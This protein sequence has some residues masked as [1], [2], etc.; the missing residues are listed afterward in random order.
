MDPLT[1]ALS[2]IVIQQVGFRRKAALL[3]LV[4]SAVAPDIDYIARI[5]GPDVFLHYHRGITHGFL[6]LAVF[7]AVMGFIFRNKGGFF[8]Y[9]FLSFL[10]YG[11]HLL[12]DLTNQYGTQILAPL[13]WNRYAL[14][15]TFII[16]PYI[17]LGL[18]LA[19]V[20]GRVNK[21]RSVVIAA[22]AVLL[23]ACYIGGRAYLQGQARQFLRSRLDANTYRVYPLPNGL[24]RWWFVVKSGDELSTGVVDL[25]MGKLFMYEKCRTDGLDSAVIVSK[26]SRVV[27]NFLDFAQ[28]PCAEVKKEHGRT[29]V[30]WRELSYLFLPGDR[31]TAEVVM[32]GNGKILK[33]GFKF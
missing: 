5:W 24:L 21:R 33:S 15:L 2:G 30:R 25:F 6:A 13:D 17:S 8:Y 18:L 4:L 14:D 27:R 32:D 22:S 1:H 16:D 23:V 11:S 20:L 7:P 3:V 29:I 10:G 26:D 9:Y 28:T 19:V 12:L 31:F